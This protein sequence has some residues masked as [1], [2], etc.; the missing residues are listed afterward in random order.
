MQIGNYKIGRY[1]AIIKKFYEDGS[2]DYETRFNDEADLQ[3]SLFAIQCCIG[4]LVGT[5]TDHPKVLTGCEAIRGRKAIEAELIT[6]D[7]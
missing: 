6:P 5:A 2:I 4:R 3:E 1:H 7:C